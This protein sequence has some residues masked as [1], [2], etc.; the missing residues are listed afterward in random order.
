M[1]CNFI[2]MCFVLYATLNSINAPFKKYKIKI[3]LSHNLT[4]IVRMYLKKKIKFVSVQK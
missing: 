4:Q 3:T 2:L 1:D